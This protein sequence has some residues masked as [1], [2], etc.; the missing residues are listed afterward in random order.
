MKNH[1]MSRRNFLKLLGLS[2]A[3]AATGVPLIGCDE[4]EDTPIPQREATVLEK[5]PYF[6]QNPA[7]GYNLDYTI[8]TGQDASDVLAAADIATGIQRILGQTIGIV[9]DS[10]TT[11]LDQNLILVGRTSQYVYPEGYNQLLDDLV[12]IE[13]GDV[14]PI[15]LDPNSG[16]RFAEDEG[17]IKIHKYGDFNHL[18]VTGYGPDQVRN[19]GKVLNQ[20]EIYQD[21]ENQLMHG[22]ALLVKGTLGSFILDEPKAE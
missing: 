7:E 4:K 6:L 17:L 10:E 5:Y 22:N 19:C 14:L 15:Q 9:L 13:P 11:S 16:E 18:I 21:P 3:V 20:P 12:S 8:V 1:D 2:A